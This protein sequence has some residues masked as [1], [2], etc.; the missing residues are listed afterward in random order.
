MG[1]NVF[2][3]LILAAIRNRAG[4]CTTSAVNV[5]MDSRTLE[6]I[7]DRHMPRKVDRRKGAC[8]D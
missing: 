5:Y 3:E 2:I 8:L 6:R 1:M 7:L 4:A